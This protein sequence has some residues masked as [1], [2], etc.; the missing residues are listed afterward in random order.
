VFKGIIVLRIIVGRTLDYYVGKGFLKGGWK[1][2]CTE[3]MRNCQLLSALF[4]GIYCLYRI[5]W[6]WES[7]NIWS[8]IAFAILFI[9]NAYIYSALSTFSK[10]KRVGDE[11]TDPG[12]PLD[13]PGLIEYHWD[14]LYLT[15]ATMIASL[16][17]NWGWLILG[18]APAYATYYLGSSLILPFFSKGNDNAED[19]SQDLKR[20]DRAE[21]RRQKAFNKR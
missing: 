10:V 20:R 4:M 19:D 13:S 5:V 11:I 15:W 21:R 7:M 17:T 9:L 14:V 1:I 12:A 6:N 18:I 3:W 8:W 2:A 16:F